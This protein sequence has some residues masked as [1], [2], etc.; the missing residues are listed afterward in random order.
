MEN[1]NLISER[2]NPLFKRKEILFSVTNQ[3]TPSKQEVEEFISNQFSTTPDTFKLKKIEGQFGAQEFKISV[4][5]YDSSE[6]KD[7]IEFKSK[8]EIEAEKKAAEE[9]AAKKAEE[10]AA[11]AEAEKPVEGESKEETSLEKE[12][13]ESKEIAEEKAEEEKE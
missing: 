11:K 7:K 12:Q 2:Q 4:N 10:E 13:E 8:K 3:T 6:E 1:Y 5:I 9:A